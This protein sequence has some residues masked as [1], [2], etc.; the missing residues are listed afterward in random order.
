MQA[1]AIGISG[2]CTFIFP[3]K[4]HGKSRRI[5]IGTRQEESVPYIMSNVQVTNRGTN[6]DIHPS[7]LVATMD[8][9]SIG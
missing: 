9:K 7:E 8:N 2:N 6:G 1:H 5:Y 4:P 3:G